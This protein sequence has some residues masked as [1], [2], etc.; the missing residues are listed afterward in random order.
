MNPV[1]YHKESIRLDMTGWE[2]DPLEIA[3]EV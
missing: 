2:D 3:Q 1:N